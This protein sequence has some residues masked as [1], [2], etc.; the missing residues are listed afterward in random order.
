MSVG[1]FDYQGLYTVVPTHNEK[2]FEGLRQLIEERD[3]RRIGINTSERWNHADGLTATQRDAL[4]EALGD[5]YRDRVVSAEMLAVGW[6]EAR[7]PEETDAYRHI[8]RVAHSVI[9]RAFSNEV[10]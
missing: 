6:L 7:L 5:E 4:F 10:I 3:P 2:Q 9:G 1:R 8:M